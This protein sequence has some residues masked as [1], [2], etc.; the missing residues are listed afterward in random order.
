MRRDTKRIFLKK[1]ACSHTFFFLLN[2][3][4]GNHNAEMEKASDPLAGGVLQEGDQCGMLWG[5]SLAVG[6]EAYR[7]EGDPSMAQSLAIRATQSIVDSFVNR[8]HSMNCRDITTTDFSNKWQMAKYMIF[9]A[10]ACF[11]LA[12]RWTGEAIAAAR[13]GMAPETGAG[14]TPCVNCASVVVQKMG[15][16]AEEQCVA[17][18]FAG[19]LGLS[20]NACGAYSAAIWMNTLKYL[21]ENP[22][23]SAYTNPYAAAVQQAFFESTNC[24]VMCGELAGRRFESVEAHSTFIQ[25]GGCKE[26]IEALA[27]AGKTLSDSSHGLTPGE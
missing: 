2:R 5:A 10:H 26:L 25:E 20:G 11:T 13:E 14:A 22:G 21:R 1:G 12:S 9:K 15:G 4:F 19:G 24:E 6:A 3:E 7:R 17:A 16:T 18:G 27:N 8:T 23:K